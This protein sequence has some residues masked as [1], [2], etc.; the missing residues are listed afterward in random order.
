VLPVVSFQQCWLNVSAAVVRVGKAIESISV[1]VIPSRAYHFRDPAVPTDLR[2]K[3]NVH[4]AGKNLE[5][6]HSFHENI[7]VKSGAWDENGVFVYATCAAQPH[8]K[9][10]CLCSVALPHLRCCLVCAFSVD[11]RSAF[12]CRN[13]QQVAH[14]GT[15]SVQIESFDLRRHAC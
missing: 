7:R 9:T 15:L 3:H 10:A 14:Y 12:A 13:S 4:M 11:S 1:S 6:L 8:V 5:Y 2:S